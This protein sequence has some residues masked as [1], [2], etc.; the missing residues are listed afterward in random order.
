[1]LPEWLEPELVSALGPGAVRAALERTR[2]IETLDT[3][4]AYFV[5]YEAEAAYL[6]GDEERCLELVDRAFAELPSAEVLLQARL[7]VRGAQAAEALG[8]RSRSLE[9]FDR[10]LQMDPGMVRR[11]G[12]SLPAR[13][14]A[15]PG[16]IARVAGKALGRS[17]RFDSAGSGGA[18]TLMVEGLADAGDACLVGPRGTR[19]ACAQVT[20]RAGESVEDT[21]RRL[22]QELHT[23]AFA[24]RLD[25]TQADLRSLD[26]SPT[27]AGG[28]NRE[29][30]TSVLRE[31]VGDPE[32]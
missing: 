11:L 26:G 9:L 17:P 30:M 32:P 20:P 6:Q 21:G 2:E 25:L 23:E 8:L 14:E 5:A 1:E 27:A 18:F 13:V 16:P 10:A 24:P 15:S 31:L 4:E 19:Y 3:A 28:R 22:A 7:A 12:A 29:R